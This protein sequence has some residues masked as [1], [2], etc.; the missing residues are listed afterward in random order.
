ME[1]FAPELAVVTHGGGGKA[2]ES[3]FAKTLAYDVNLLVSLGIRL[4]LVHGGMAQNVGPILEM[5]TEKYLLRCDAEW[6]A[7]H[8]MLG[9]LNEILGGLRAGN[10][11]AI[12]SATTLKSIDCS[13]IRS[14][15]ATHVRPCRAPPTD[16]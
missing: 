7:R 6:K 2:V 10:I 11:Q 15:R 1:G 9:I 16:E 4:V 8:S 13:R 3:E 14:P 5:V 12:G